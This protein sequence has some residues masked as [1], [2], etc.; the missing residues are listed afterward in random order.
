MGA[1]RLPGPMGP[2]PN[3]PKN[4]SPLE[5]TRDE[6]VSVRHRDRRVGRRR[7]MRGRDPG[8]RGLR[9]RRAREGRLPQRIRF[10][11][12]RGRVDARHVPLRD[13][14]RH[15]RSRRADHRRL[16]LGGGTVVNYTTSFKT[17]PHVLKEWAQVSGIDA[18]VSGEIEE[19]LDAAAERLSVN[20][21]SSAAGR[22]DEL[23]EE[24]LKKLGWHV[25]ALPRGRQ[26]LH[27][28]RALRVLRFRLPSG[29]EAVVDAHVARG[30]AAER[31]AHHHRSRRPA[32]QDLERA[33]HRG[34]GG[35]ERTPLGRER[36]G[37]RRLGRFD[38][39]AGAAPAVRSPRV[40]S[41]IT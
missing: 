25:D 39:I 31:R 11:P 4:L 18:F 24:G 7:R 5:V 27:A 16:D 29:G 3:A 23:L 9:R 35:R 36:E 41:V 32:R 33:R 30:C 38:R 2:P 40:A 21:D 28:G 6:V 12:S 17:P 15:R 19:S 26:G 37:G 22:R 10:P 8:R 1:H 14:P 13:D 34:R 20:T